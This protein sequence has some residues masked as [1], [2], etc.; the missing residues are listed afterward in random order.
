MG[1]CFI[2]GLLLKYLFLFKV[3]LSS[4]LNLLLALLAGSWFLVTV[5]AFSAK[6]LQTVIF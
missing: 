3:P 5:L 2:Y 1:R 6:I 4:S